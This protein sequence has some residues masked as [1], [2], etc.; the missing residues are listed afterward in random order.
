MRSYIANIAILFLMLLAAPL[1]ADPVYPLRGDRGVLESYQ[2]N[3]A[4]WLSEDRI[5]VADKRFNNFQ[6]FDTQGRRY[7]LFDAQSL[8]A[9]VQYTGLTRLDETTFLAVGS[10]YHEKNHPRYRKQRSQLHRFRLIGEDLI[11]SD[12]SE[13]YSPVESFRMLRLWGETPLRQMEVAGL[14][15]DEERDL[16]WFGLSTPLSEQGQLLLLSAS[17]KEVLARKPG[18]VVNEVNTEFRLPEEERC[19]RPTYLTDLS[20]LEDGSLLV[21]LTS[22]D[23]EAKRFCSSSLWRIRPGHA[24]ERL[25][26]DLAPGERATGMALLPLGEGS[27]RV[28]LVCDNE[29]E[30]TGIPSKLVILE[31]PIEIDL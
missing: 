22:D 30:T 1:S 17:L 26:H 10:H 4:V 14:G 8:S 7:L 9:P 28:A 2:P 19:G 24:A 31:A 11:L 12:F 21:L 3:G 29:P 5:L 6:I 18:L 25:R 16:I 15:V 27:Y 13:D 20:V 23:L